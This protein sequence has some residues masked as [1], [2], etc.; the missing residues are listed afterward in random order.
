VAGEVRRRRWPLKPAERTRIGYRTLLEG[1]IFA[2]EMGG[3]MDSQNIVNRH[4]K[5]LLEAAKLPKIRL[6]DLRHSSATLLIEAGEHPK[7]VQ[8]RL[9]HSTIQLTLDTYTHVVPGMRER[10]A[11]KL[12]SLLDAEER[13]RKTRRVPERRASGSHALDPRSAVAVSLS[14]ASLPASPHRPDPSK[15]LA[16]EN[17]S[18]GPTRAWLGRFRAFSGPGGTRTHDRTIMSRLL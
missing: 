5:P 18:S 4:F 16:R 9:G 3:L 7:V 10:A 15:N 6:Y 14:A 12:E 2:S 13:R 11:A 1:L 17:A 8:E